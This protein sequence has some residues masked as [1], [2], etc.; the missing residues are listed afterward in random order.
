MTTQQASRAGKQVIII[1]GMH[2]SGT[3]ASTGA[4][5]CV[6]VD[7]GDKL[8]SGHKGINDK[9][10]FEH[11]DIA[12]TNDEV[13]AT[14]GSCWDDVLLKEDGWWHKTELAPYADK[15]RGHIRRDFSTSMLWAVKDPR[16][17]RLLPWWL[18]ILASLRIDPY[19]IFVVR[20]PDAVYRSL[21]RR[22]GFSREKS[23]LLWSLHYLEAEHW[24][25]GHSRVFVDF[26]HF[27]ENP[28]DSLL[29]IECELG[30]TYPVPVSHAGPCLK[31]FLS[32]DMRHHKKTEVNDES[33]P[34]IALTQELHQQ[35]LTATL[36]GP[37]SLE[38]AVMD[39]LWARMEAL[40]AEFPRM[41]VEHIRT[42]GLPRGALQV[43]MNKL[44][45]SWSWY[46]GKPVRFMERLIGR[47]V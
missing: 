18:E 39:D 22:D 12:D 3:S 43:T 17:C 34:L 25:R 41:L 26:D 24:S 30:I 32:S 29:K 14:L 38:P 47:D 28:S 23:F 2:R 1:V 37:S 27:L 4:L 40:Q 46:A 11:T 35:L 31:Q 21:E 13:L 7:L 45:R 16:V 36:S 20:S 44:V 8:Y 10:Y 6:G 42:I 9:G 33:A 19:F 15:I 5:R